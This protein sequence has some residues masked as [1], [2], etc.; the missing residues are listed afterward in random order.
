MT[1]LARSQAQKVGQLAKKSDFSKSL[2]F[3]GKVKTEI[4]HITSVVRYCSVVLDKNLRICIIIDDIDLLSKQ[5]IM[6]LFQVKQS[7]FAFSNIFFQ[8][9]DW[10]S[11]H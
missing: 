3:L 7:R 8:F 1:N 9:F 2:G 4:F 6:N 10:I 5:Q 11:F